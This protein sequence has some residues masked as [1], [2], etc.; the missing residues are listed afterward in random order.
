MEEYYGKS[1]VRL[2]QKER[3]VKKKP[4]VKKY[5]DVDIF[6]DVAL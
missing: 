6:A 1:R 4:K 3:V 5:D 2:R